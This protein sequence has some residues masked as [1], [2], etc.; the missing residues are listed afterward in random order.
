M[1]NQLNVGFNDKLTESIVVFQT[2]TT[3]TREV[4][5]VCNFI[6]KKLKKSFEFIVNRV[7]VLLSIKKKRKKK[8]LGSR[9]TYEASSQLFRK[10]LFTDGD[11]DRHEKGRRSA[12]TKS[13]TRAGSQIIITDAE[14]EGRLTN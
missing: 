13:Y 11:D 4:G 7:R 8:S 3:K 6:K 12:C 2:G 10:N 9:R 1:F 5:V 14:L